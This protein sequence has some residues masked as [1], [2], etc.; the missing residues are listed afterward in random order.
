MQEERER[1]RERAREIERA[2][3]RSLL[4]HKGGATPSEREIASGRVFRL[5]TWAQRI[6]THLDHIS[7]CK[8]TFGMNW[9]NRWTYR[10]FIINSRRD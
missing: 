5:N 2:R 3:K 1:E 7:H 8:T 9:S 10:V 4:F 6:T